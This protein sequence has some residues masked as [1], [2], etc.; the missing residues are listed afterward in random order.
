MSR[1]PRRAV[2][3][4]L[5][6]SPPGRPLRHAIVGCGR[7]APSH[8][9][10]FARL[11]EAELAACCDLDL[12]KARALAERFSARRVYASLKD[13]LA[14][15]GVDSVS[16]CLPHHLHAPVAEQALQ[17]G[18]HVLLEKPF[19]MD[20]AEAARLAAAARRSGRILQP[21]CQHRFDFVVR[22]VKEIVSQHLGQICMA[23]AHLECRRPPEYYSQS[24]W[25][26]RWK[27]EGGSVSINQAYHVLDLLL[28][29]LGPLDRVGA[30]MATLT[31]G[32]LMETE[33]SLVANL[34][35]AN[36]GLGSLTVNGASGAQWHSYIE[37]CGSGGVVAFDIGYPNQVPRLQLDSRRALQSWRKAFAEHFKACPLPTAGID[38]YG[39]SHRHEAAEFAARI[40]GQ[41]ATVS[42][43]LQQ[44]ESVVR[45][46]EAL[47]RSA[48]QGVPIALT[49]VADARA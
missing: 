41:Q 3:A 46:V 14:D 44:A 9:D 12:D 34:L 1:K 15:A 43:T 13:L 23:R 20:G 42:C 27:T 6:S 28:W 18:K 49:E 40:D 17:A 36:S 11:P 24:D 2:E 30:Q 16:L 32:K 7:V 35:F 31:G 8:A 37:I 39:D 29:L 5:V 21:V 33:D 38:Y 10:A 26:G 47:Y 25:R 4:G 19:A 22:S 45:A 48:R